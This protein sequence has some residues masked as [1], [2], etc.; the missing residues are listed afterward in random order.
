MKEKRL[1]VALGALTVALAACGSSGTP[2]DSAGNNTG[3]GGSTLPPSNA[4]N[5]GAQNTTPQNTAGNAGTAATVDPSTIV[6][7]P[8]IPVTTQIPRLLNRQYENVVRD[9]LGVTSLDGNPVSASLLGDFT[10][11]MNAPGWTIYNTVATKIAANVMAGPTKSM[12]I[13]CDPATA[14]CLEQTVRTFGRKAFRRPLTDDEVAS[15]MTLNAVTP[16]GTPAEVAEAILNAFLVSPSFLMIPELATD[17]EGSSI[18]LSA[19]EVAARLSFM[20]WGSVPDD[21][22]N[23]AADAN[24]LATKDQILAQATRMI[25]LRD[26]SGQFISAFH[27]DWA[28]MNNSSGHWYQGNHD[29]AKFPAFTAAAKTAGQQE[30]DMFF[31]EVAFTG[32]SFKD[33]LLSNIAFVSSDNAAQYGLDPSKYTTTLTKVMLDPATNPRPG[34][35]TR[36]GFLSSYADYGA[37]SPILRGAFMSI[38]LL[39]VNPGA[40]SPDNLS[41]TVSG[42]FTT[43]RAYVEALTMQKQPCLGCHTVFNPLGFVFESYDAIGKWQ[44]TDLLGGAINATA[45]VD[46]GGGNK[47]EISS[48]TQ[49]MQEIAALPKAQAIYAQDWV[50][51]AYGRQPNANDQC[52]VN[53][54]Q[55]K[56][57]G[58]GYS[59]LALLGD[60]TQTDSFR[61]RVRGT[62]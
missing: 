55:T 17:T 7:Q 35:L 26:K 31:Q 50:S 49:L 3:G 21:T 2:A 62:P 54:L 18:K 34:F 9:L 51:Y 60:L 32:G 52:V 19:T 58:D 45:T 5:A 28:Q 48:P 20:L 22:L 53:T 41:Q 12:F 15:F 56:L 38:Y 4:G 6:C 10:G 16:A 57:A 37:S 43:Q 23:A 11:P 27:D 8:G 30:T 13:A 29:P 33:L 59:I 25:A 24:Q 1:L 40:P 61:L 44:T 36:T 42:T 46:F 47:K 39:N 14:G